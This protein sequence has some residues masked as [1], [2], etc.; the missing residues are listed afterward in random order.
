MSTEKQKNQKA[1]Q[2][3]VEAME[4]IGWGK[5]NGHFRPVID[6]DTYFAG[7]L[8]SPPEPEI[9]AEDIA[10]LSELFRSRQSLF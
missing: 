3:C 6:R 7:T 2:S 5:N 9:S 1:P 10:L 8:P 4:S